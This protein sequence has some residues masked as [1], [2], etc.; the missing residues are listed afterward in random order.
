MDKHDT[1]YEHLSEMGLT[2]TMSLDN[3]RPN[4]LHNWKVLL[5]TLNYKQCSNYMKGDDYNVY[6]CFCRRARTHHACTHTH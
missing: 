6:T 4:K 2:I 5:D 1:D 3:I